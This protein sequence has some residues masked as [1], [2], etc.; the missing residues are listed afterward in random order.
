MASYK[1]M[2]KLAD[3]GG[4]PGVRSRPNA[5]GLVGR[6]FQP[7]RLGGGGAPR[8][9]SRPEGARTRP[10]RQIGR[11]LVGAFDSGL[12]IEGDNE[13]PI[14]RS[15][16]QSAGDG[17]AADVTPFFGEMF[18]VS[19]SSVEEV[20]LE[21]N[22]SLCGQKG[23]PVSNDICKRAGGWNVDEKME[24]VW[25]D[26]KQME[27]PFPRSLVETSRREDFIGVVKQGGGPTVFRRDGDEVYGVCCVNREWASMV[28]SFPNGKQEAGVGID[29][30]EHSIAYRAL[31]RARI[32]AAPTG[33]GRTGRGRSARSALPT[34]WGVCPTG[35]DYLFL[36]G[37]K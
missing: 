26:E 31:G 20:F 16:N 25:H 12:G 15:R 19:D 28:Q 9:R 22:S 17:I 37:R 23:F 21:V 7:C 32:P 24:M 34:E 18:S 35:N 36:K 6:G 30:H 27:K 33:R 5:D 2:I 13:R 10:R 14:L 1:Q 11:L 4:A 8:V 29:W 3:G